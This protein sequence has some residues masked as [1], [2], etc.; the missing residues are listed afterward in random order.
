MTFTSPLKDIT[1]SEGETVTLECE[2]SKAG[3]PVEWLRNGKKIP[4]SDKNVTISAEGPKHSLTL[5]DVKVDDS[6]EFTA[7]VGDVSTAAKLTVQG[8]LVPA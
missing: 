5:K 8:Q 7:K 1:T 3:Q 6:A 4:K 2:L